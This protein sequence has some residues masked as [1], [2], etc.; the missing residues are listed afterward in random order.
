[1]DGQRAYG[2]TQYTPTNIIT[3]H[4]TKFWVHFGVMP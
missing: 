2:E 3:A 4:Y 1:M